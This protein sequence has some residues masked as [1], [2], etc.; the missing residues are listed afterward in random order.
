M[1]VGWVSLMKIQLTLFA[2]YWNRMR[3]YRYSKLKNI[4]N[5]WY[6][7]LPHETISTTIHE[8]LE[9][10]KVS[11][12]WIPK[13]LTED[14]KVNRLA[15]TDQFRTL[16]DANGEDLFDRIVINDEKWVHQFVPKWKWIRSSGLIREDELRK[17]K[18]WDELE[19]STWSV[20][21]CEGILLEEYAPKGVTTT[22]ETYF[23]MLMQRCHKNEMARKTVP[24]D[25]P[26][27]R[28]GSSSQRG[29]NP[30]AP[31]RFLVGYLSTCS[32]LTRPC[33]I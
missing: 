4:F 6:D 23:D 17:K 2:G 9:K 8:H 3:K 15:A 19:K 14:R 16:Y 11:A 25:P 12:R 27:E 18:K 29:P 7:L 1:L 20:L 33:A 21:N 31:R 26:F 32:V 28:Q 13:I 24:A 5:M 30:E 22:K 10:K